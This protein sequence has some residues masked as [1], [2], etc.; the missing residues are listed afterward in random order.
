LIARALDLA[1]NAALLL[2]FFSKKTAKA[3]G[4]RVEKVYRRQFSV[5]SRQFSVEIFAGKLTTDD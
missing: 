4:H 3:E 5:V 1:Q 2:L